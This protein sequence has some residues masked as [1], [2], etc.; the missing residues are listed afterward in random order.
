MEV[1]G[2]HYAA[3]VKPFTLLCQPDGI[4]VLAP[5]NVQRPA[6]LTAVGHFDAER[7]WVHGSAVANR[8]LGVGFKV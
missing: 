5:A 2:N 7:I 1:L 8:R 3:G 4:A 6:W